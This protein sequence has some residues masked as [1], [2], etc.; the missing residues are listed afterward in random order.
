MLVAA[1]ALVTVG[2]PAAAAPAPQ[3]T[4]AAS[5]ESESVASQT[6][7]AQRDPVAEADATRTPTPASADTPAAAADT[8]THGGPTR[9]A[10]FDRASAVSLILIA[11]GV[12]VLTLA[13]RRG[14][15]TP[16]ESRPGSLPPHGPTVK[17]PQPSMTGSQ[18][19]LGAFALFLAAPLFKG[20]LFVAAFA[21]N[22]IDPASPGAMDQLPPMLAVGLLCLAYLLALGAGVGLIAAVKPAFRELGLHRPLRQ[23]FRVSMKAAVIVLPLTFAAAALVSLATD[24]WSHLRSAPAPDD[25]A[26]ATLREIVADPFAPATI[27]TVLMVTLL[28]PVFEE[29]VYRGFLQSGF[30]RLAGRES[31]TAVWLA[32]GSSSVLFTLAHVQ[33]ADLRA[34]PVLLVLSLGM[35]IA[36][37]RTGTLWA[38]IPIHIAFNAANVGLA[39]MG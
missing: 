12:G 8:T 29:L 15:L 9:G 35:G 14:W 16:P 39:I 10:L 20:L 30:R 11:V 25:I 33:A 28:V 31:R 6:P 17:T 19:L 36:Y 5:S 13:L 3:P 22:D 23:S 27:L 21:M 26:H 1:L 38:P 32:I 24:I 4:Q 2:S 37:E 34:F 7:P 18:L